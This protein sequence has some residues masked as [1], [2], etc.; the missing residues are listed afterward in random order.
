MLLTV[1]LLVIGAAAL[2]YHRASLKLWD[3]FALSYLL[4][5]SFYAPVSHLTV[6]FSWLLVGSLLAVLNVPSLRQK[7]F[8]SFAYKIASR[9]LPSISDTERLALESGTVSWD[10]ELFSGMPKWSKLFNYKQARMTPEEQAFLEGP[11]EEACRMGNNWDMWH[12]NLE[13]PKDLAKFVRDN[14]FMGMNIPKE[15]GGKEFSAVGIWS[16]IMKINSHIGPVGTEIVI[17]NSIGSAELLCLYGT[18]KQKK[19]FLPRLAKGLDISCFALTSPVAG[20]DAT[21][22]EDHGVICKKKVDG[23]EILGIRLN[24]NKRYITLAPIA[25][26]MG[27]AF[28]L[29]DPNHLVGKKED[30]GISLAIIPTKLPGITQ[31]RRHYP[32]GV[33]FP[34]GPLQG[35]DV[36]IPLDSLLGGLE[37]AGKGWMMLAHSLAGGRATSLPTGAVGTCKHTF[38]TTTV[39][40]GI[41][42]QFGVTLGQFQGVQEK[43]TELA[44]FAYLTDATR[45]FTFSQLEAGENPAITAAI[46]KYNCTE[47][48]RQSAIHAMDLHGGKAVMHGPHNYIA[49]HY[50]TAPVGVTVEG[51]NTMTRNLIVFGQGAIRCHPYILSEMKALQTQDFTQFDN[52]IVKHLSYTLSNHIRSLILGV[53]KGC[54]VRV[55]NSNGMIR[56][57]LQYLTHLSAAFALLSDM[58]LMT[59]GGKLKS[60]ESLSGKF[61]D[62][63]SMLFMSS[64][65]I[66]HYHDQGAPASIQPVV[67]WTLE[68]AMFKAQTNLDAIL[69][70]FPNQFLSIGL[71]LFVFPLGKRYKAPSDALSHEVAT[72][73]QSSKAAR[74]LLA[75]GIYLTPGKDSIITQLE[76]ALEHTG[77]VA[78]LEKKISLATRQGTLKGY[79]HLERIAEAKK[80][81][82]ITPPEEKA[83]LAAHK[84]IMNIIHVDDF[85]FD[86]LL[87][88]K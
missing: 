65:V 32:I 59:I 68:W 37:L 64:A 62:V 79:T 35:K 87:K 83:L 66:K 71:R 67:R 41:R 6:I 51:S 34:N 33:P 78:E 85:S 70:N 14:G 18:E 82:L 11:A 24:F 26:L 19:Y 47:L 52:L 21:A 84:A 29:Y 22:I 2:S 30:I 20:S 50:L 4:L 3:A 58:A 9:K 56:K 39:Y 40:T 8:T 76:D 69:D 17:A 13:T 25:T 7:V 55:P 46:S 44:G 77:K 36:F 81:G 43:L 80:V 75:E 49:D 1:S 53:T 12:K 5:I 23:K 72:L 28:R 74:E 45:L 16:I 38:Y 63:L 57:H 15:Y 42:K 27:L 60:K 61:A 86:Q 88:E 31:G 54:F 10:A 73:V 48:A